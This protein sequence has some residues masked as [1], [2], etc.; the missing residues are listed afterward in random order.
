MHSAC[1]QPV[2][3]HLRK[4][5]SNDLVLGSWNHTN[6]I[7]PICRN[8][9]LGSG[10]KSLISRQLN[11]AR[12]KCIVF[13]LLAAVETKAMVLDK[14]AAKIVGAW[15]AW[16]RSTQRKVLLSP[17]QCGGKDTGG[18]PM[19]SDTVVLRRPAFRSLDACQRW[20][21]EEYPCSRPAI[22]QGAVCGKQPSPCPRLPRSG[23]CIARTGGASHTL[24]IPSSPR[25]CAPRA[26]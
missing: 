14:P 22:E 5:R 3:A 15:C 7:F 19:Y 26:S 2:F 20:P 16:F 21:V 9:M 24:H 4:L 11:L 6:T 23:R 1:A 10:G 25:K 12:P 8:Y 17:R 18:C 13:G